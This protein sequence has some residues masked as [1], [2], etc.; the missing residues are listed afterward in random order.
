MTRKTEEKQGNWWRRVSEKQHMLDKLCGRQSRKK[1][2][3]VCHHLRT[4]YR[5]TVG[6]GRSLQQVMATVWYHQPVSTSPAAS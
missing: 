6:E 1:V 2:C 5:S 4:V 3:E